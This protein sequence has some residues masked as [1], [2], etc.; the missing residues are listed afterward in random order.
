MA[1]QLGLGQGKEMMAY[2]FGLALA[3]LALF[4]ERARS[5]ARAS[6][7]NIFEELVLFESLRE[8]CVTT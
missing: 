8:L 5:L 3:R 2:S 7:A 6:R 4:E 1:G